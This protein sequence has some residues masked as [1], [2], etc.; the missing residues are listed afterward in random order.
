MVQCFI[1]ASVDRK[2]A[3]S[4]VYSP[5]IESFY[6]EISMFTKGLTI[7]QT[8]TIAAIIMSASYV[9][10]CQSEVDKHGVDNIPADKLKN[11]YELHLANE[12]LTQLFGLLICDNSKKWKPLAIA[13]V[14]SMNFFID[15]STLSREELELSAEELHPDNIELDYDFIESVQH[16]KDT[17]ALR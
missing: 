15:N 16:K 10:V 9:V 13:Y 17:Q 12:Y 3:T 5:G 1:A 14:C 6:N 11:M 4:I 7:Q 8:A 2:L